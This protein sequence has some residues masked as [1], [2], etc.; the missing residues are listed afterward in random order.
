MGVDVVSQNTILNLNL[1]L[2]K[3]MFSQR[4]DKQSGAQISMGS[5]PDRPLRY[6][7]DYTGAAVISMDGLFVINPKRIYP[8]LSPRQG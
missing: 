6:G 2:S 5:I 7:L 3:I 8:D 1:A 4:L